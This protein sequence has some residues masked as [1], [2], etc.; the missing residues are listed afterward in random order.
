VVFI[1]NF[2]GTFLKFLVY[3]VLYD[4]MLGKH[5]QLAKFTVGGNVHILMTVAATLLLQIILKSR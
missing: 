4:V 1:I 5:F 3:E 2:I